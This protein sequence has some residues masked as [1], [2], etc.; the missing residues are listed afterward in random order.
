MDTFFEAASE[1]YTRLVT[2]LAPAAL[3]RQDTGCDSVAY[4]LDRRHSNI[5]LARVGRDSQAV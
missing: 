5:E 1:G 2:S 3:N 4:Y